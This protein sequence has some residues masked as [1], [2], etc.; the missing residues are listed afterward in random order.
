MKS[1]CQSKFTKNFLLGLA[2]WPDIYTRVAECCTYMFSLLELRSAP[3]IAFHLLRSE[4]DF[5][6]LDLADE[7]HNK[8][9]LVFFL[10]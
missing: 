8:L 2:F 9:E 6:T 3:L 5:L 4:L 1:Q 7:G 10:F